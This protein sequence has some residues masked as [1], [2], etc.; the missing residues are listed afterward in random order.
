M[1]R[2]S[3]F[4]CIL[5]PTMVLAGPNE[6][7]FFLGLSAGPTWATGNKNQ[8]FNL[9]PDVIKTYQ[10]KNDSSIFPSAEL[11]LGRQRWVCISPTLPL[12][13]Q[14]GLEFAAA[15]QA[16]LH[17]D[18]WEDADPTFDNYTYH[19]KINHTH[20]GLKVRFVGRS[21]YLINPY[22]NAM[23]GAGFNHAYDFTIN[24]KIPEEVAAPA[25]KSKNH[26]C[27]FLCT[28]CWFANDI[29]C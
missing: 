9:Q 10:A 11:F 27:I 7:H 28:W 22:F 15:G 20:V 25:F 1:V 18:I 12:V 2:S 14:F 5:F 13:A 24:P 6:N 19:Y 23:I 17:G 8:T 16:K 26:E 21:D 3:I 4:I 29:K